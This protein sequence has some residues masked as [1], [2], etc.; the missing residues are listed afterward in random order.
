MRSFPLIISSAIAI[1]LFSCT[2]TRQRVVHEGGFTLRYDTVSLDAESFCPEF[3]RCEL[4]EGVK[5]GGDY[6]LLFS[7]HSKEPGSKLESPRL[8]KLDS[9]S[10]SFSQ[11]PFPPFPESGLGDI[12][13]RG[14]TLFFKSLYFEN[15]GYYFDFSSE[16]WVSMEKFSNIVYEND[17]VKVAQLYHGEWGDDAWFIEKSTGNQYYFPDNLG[18]IVPFKG[19]WYFSRGKQLF[20]LSDYHSG[21]LCDSAT[22]YESVSR[23]RE[24]WHYFVERYAI[25]KGVTAFSRPSLIHTLHE[26]NPDPYYDFSGNT[27]VFFE[28]SFVSGDNLFHFVT[29]TLSS[30]IVR[31]GKDTVYTLVDLRKRYTM[32]ENHFR[33]IR[34]NPP[35]GESLVLYRDDEKNSGVVDISGRDLRFIHFRNAAE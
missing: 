1:A 25:S 2:S 24:H 18:R 26:D 7:V 19:V 5:L 21:F 32:Q 20:G 8:F 16:K 30:K 23:K 27:S 9:S 10:L 11:L 4:S 22:T 14:D 34:F 33:E 13:S 17:Q 29:D 15:K 12:I 28:T 3:S 35:E 31:V 6:Y